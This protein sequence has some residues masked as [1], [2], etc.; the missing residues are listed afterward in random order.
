MVNKLSV[1]TNRGRIRKLTLAIDEY[2][3][4]PDLAYSLVDLGTDE[5]AFIAPDGSYS[6]REYKI[7][8]Q[9]DESGKIELDP[10]AFEELCDL[11]SYFKFRLFSGGELKVEWEAAWPDRAGDGVFEIELKRPKNLRE[12]DTEQELEQKKK[13]GQEQGTRHKKPRGYQFI[14]AVMAVLVVVAF[15]VIYQNKYSFRSAKVDCFEPEVVLQAANNDDLKVQF[16]NKCIT[17]LSQLD[18]QGYNDLLASWISADTGMLEIIGDFYNPYISDD[19][20]DGLKPDVGDMAS[21]TAATYYLQASQAGLQNAS[22]K[23][24]SLCERVED[25]TERFFMQEQCRSFD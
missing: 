13:Q 23:L 2:S 7:S 4:D 14:Y 24:R 19:L 25:D 15:L 1:D 21:S 11:G 5:Q 6:T 22:S 3:N 10:N 9:K 18:E 12:L 17:E 8:I 16:R 20:L